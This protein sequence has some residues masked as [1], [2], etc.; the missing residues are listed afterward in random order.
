[1]FWVKFSVSCAAVCAV[2][3]PIGQALAQQK[4]NFSKIQPIIGRATNKINSVT[5]RAYPELHQSQRSNDDETGL[6]LGTFI[7]EPKWE[8]SGIWSSNIERAP[9]DANADF[10]LSIKPEI[11][12]KSD[13][14]RHEVSGKIGG[15]LTRFIDTNAADINALNANVNARID[16]RSDTKIELRTGFDLSS[17]RAGSGEVPG[18][19]IGNRRGTT[20][21]GGLAITHD[22]GRLQWRGSFDLNY[23]QFGNVKLSDG[24]IENNNDR[25]VLDAQIALRTSYNTDGAL[26]PFIQLNY[27]PRLYQQKRDRNNIKRSSQGF[28]I[29]AGLSFDDGAIWSGEIAASYQFR[30]PDDATLNDESVIGLNGNLTW[31]PLET[32]KLTLSLGTNLNETLSTSKTANRNWSAALNY[33]QSISDFLTWNAGSSLE[34]ED[35]TTGLEKTY[36]LSTSVEYDIN[37]SFAWSIG[38]T[39]TWFDT[40]DSPSRDYN[41]QRLLTS[42]V[43]R[44]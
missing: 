18:A 34:L 25:D 3:S 16:V 5:D 1:M 12:F 29:D 22:F 7:V 28:G 23:N 41:E 43:L 31:R 14:S 19:A 26:S 20:T 24:G 9:E 38:Y 42:I 21:S 39:G 11:A 15:D 13:W 8:I 2:F 4:S 40:K 6:R 44:R 37:R 17:T 35:T 30:N 33:E 10:G 36:G 32:S 27:T